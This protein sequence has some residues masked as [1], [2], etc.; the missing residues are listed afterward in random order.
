MWDYLNL[1]IVFFDDG[2]VNILVMLRKWSE[3]DRW[4]IKL[5]TNHAVVFF[6]LIL[7]QY[8]NSNK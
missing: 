4:M 3:V 5:R 2:L 1:V 6:I 8:F 7:C